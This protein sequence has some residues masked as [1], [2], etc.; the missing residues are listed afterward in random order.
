[1]GAADTRVRLADNIIRDHCA[2][3]TNAFFKSRIQVQPVESMDLD[4]RNAAET[5]LKWLMFQHCLDDLRREVRLAAEFR[6]TYGPG[7]SW[8]SIG[9]RPPARRSSGSP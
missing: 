6:E 8:P 4:K 7:P 2:I 1:M 5:V 3:L 9:S